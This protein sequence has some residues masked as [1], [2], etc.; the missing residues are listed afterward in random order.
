MLTFVFMDY[1]FLQR[2]AAENVKTQKLGNKHSQLNYLQLELR[3]FLRFYKQLVQ[4]VMV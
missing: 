1:E 3:R 2:F 4:Y